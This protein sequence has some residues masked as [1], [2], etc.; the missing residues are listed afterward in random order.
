MVSLQVHQFLQSKLGPM[1]L[2]LILG[3]G[4]LVVNGKNAR[5]EHTQRG[6]Y[7]QYSLSIANRFRD[8]CPDLL[9]PKIK[10][11]C[12]L[13]KIR[14]NP[15][16]LTTYSCQMFYTRNHLIFTQL[17]QIFYPNGKKIIPMNIVTKYFTEE[18]LLYLYLDDGR[19]GRYG[20][21][22]LG[23]DLCN[24]GEQ[25]LIGFQKYLTT[26]FQLEVNIHKQNK[27]RALYIKMDSSKRLLSRFNQID[28]KL[29]I[30]DSVGSIWS[31]KIQ[32]KAVVSSSSKKYF[33]NGNDRSKTVLNTP[34]ESMNLDLSSKNKLIGIL[35]GFVVARANFI[36]NKGDKTG[37]IRLHLKKDALSMK[38]ILSSLSELNPKIKN[39][40]DHKFQIGISVDQPLM[41]HLNAI[42]GSENQIQNLDQS[43]CVQNDWFWRALFAYKGR[44]LSHQRGGFTVALNHLTVD[45][46]QYLS[47][48]LNQIYFFET[49]LRYRDKKT[50]AS[51]YINV[52]DYDRFYQLF[53]T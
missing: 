37:S 34:Q 38:S 52:K 23:L 7:W 25:E 10:D 36:R 41:V 42:V 21:S 15:E 47:S 43:S 3:D 49:R 24:F 32:L 45:Q 2:G 13:P 33:G 6:L 29:K 17:Y 44:D 5:F 40:G 11:Q 27:Y 39:L 12:F 31:T 19:V 51:I 30:S 18:S 14:H 16:S 8:V 53:G 28:Q 50:K 9:T 20:R 35:Q 46:V 48:M 4:S 26:E 1:W 22:G